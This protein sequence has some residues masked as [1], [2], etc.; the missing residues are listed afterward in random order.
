MDLRAASTASAGFSPVV[1][2]GLS[3]VMPV[4]DEERTLGESLRALGGLVGIDEVVV[5]DGGSRD[6]TAAIVRSFPSVRWVEA[7]RGRASQMNAG[8]IASR[9]A[10]LLFLHADVRLPSGA[11]FWVRDTLARPDVVAG[12][13]QTWTVARPPAPSPRWAPLLHL[14]DLRSR[15]SRLPYGD[16]AMFMRRSTFEAVGGFGDEA[17][18]EDLAMSQRLAARG[19]IA[20]VPARVEVDGRR[21][22]ARPVYYTALDN[23]FPTLYRLGVPPGELARWYGKV[24]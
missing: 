16:Q 10:S 6:A 20:I 21:F 14:A 13:F 7:P 4:L 22:V 2:G 12:A 23:V 1:P 8:A 5:V 24:R 19:R 9:C 11:A 15:T 3:V 18:L 17:I